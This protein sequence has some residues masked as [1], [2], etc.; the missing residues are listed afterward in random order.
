[1]YI[2]R[3]RNYVIEALRKTHPT[4]NVYF[5]TYTTPLTTKVISQNITL[6][7]V[8]DVK[9]LANLDKIYF[10]F[11]KSDIRPDAAKELDKVVKLMTVTYPNMI[12][13][14]EAHTDPIGSD[15]YND[16]LSE[17]RAKSTY[18]YLIEHGVLK[19]HI[20]SYKGYGK[21]RLINHCTSRKDCTDEELELNRR[22][23]F[24]IV[25]IKKPKDLIVKSK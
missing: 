5:N 3:E 11:N 17:R 1:M 2:N 7:P 10:D 12:I 24:P 20:L 22:T 6:E 13:H 23:E 19:E 15:A 9:L 18:D 21:R 8:M 25:Q 14:L 16:N 4:K